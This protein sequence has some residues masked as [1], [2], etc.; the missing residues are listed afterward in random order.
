MMTVQQSSPRPAHKHP[1][2]IQPHTSKH[3]L[4]SSGSSPLLSAAT[5]ATT[6]S[7]YS[8]SINDLK[9]FQSES[10]SHTHNPSAASNDDGAG[11][12][13]FPASGS[14]ADPAAAAAAA[15]VPIETQ[16][17]QF[18]EFV[19]TIVYLFLDRLPRDLPFSQRLSAPFTT[20]PKYSEF[21]DSFY[22]S[23]QLIHRALKATS[24][25][26]PL[27][28]VVAALK[29]IARIVELSEY[30][31]SPGSEGYLF[32]IALMT[33]QKCLADNVYANSTWA[34]ITK[35]PV[36]TLNTLEFEFLSCVDY[37]LHLHNTEY[38]EFYKYIHSV[39]RLW[40]KPV[41]ALPPSEETPITRGT[42]ITR[43][44]T[45]TESVKPQRSKSMGSR[46][47]LNLQTATIVNAQVFK[48]TMTP[49]TPVEAKPKSAREGEGEGDA[50]P[51]QYPPSQAAYNP[52]GKSKSFSSSQP[53][54]APPPITPT[55][56][57]PPAVAKTR[58]NAAS[59]SD[60]PVEPQRKGSL[61]PSLLS[62]CNTGSDGQSAVNSY[63]GSYGGQPIP[64]SPLHY[65]SNGSG[66]WNRKMS[67]SPAPGTSPPHDRSSQYQRLSGA[68]LDSGLQIH[69]SNLKRSTRPHSASPEQDGRGS[70]TPTPPSGPRS[71][72]PTNKRTFGLFSGSTFTLTGMFGM[73]PPMPISAAPSVVSD[74]KRDG[75]RPVYDRS[76][77][78]LSPIPPM[79]PPKSPP[80]KYISPT[81]TK[82][83]NALMEVSIGR[84]GSGSGSAVGSSSYSA[85][86]NG[87]SGSGSG[88]GSGN[89][90]SYNFHPPSPLLKG[91]IQ[92]RK[93]LL[94]SLS[95]ANPS[96]QTVG[97]GSG[98]ELGRSDSVSKSSK[99]K[100]TIDRSQEIAM[101]LGQASL[102]GK[103]GRI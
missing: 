46:P 97:R 86:S 88:S 7:L 90:Q 58:S 89:D 1:A 62:Y 31:S 22:C 79:S 74:S 80:P 32:C 81:L 52:R 43:R 24:K 12:A 75:S 30:A 98:S 78:V 84:G 9:K 42:A 38:E 64:S 6:A 36:E 77:V 41:T 102:H 56:S 60:R 26:I 48:T 34:K 65:H 76:S 93:K 87:S 39:A 33:S 29:L 101:L 23:L 91:S 99:S 71:A 49:T 72:T 50:A 92:R 94:Q 44:P 73:L 19:C 68:V 85:V 82:V 5:T 14:S 17:L 40:A 63:V 10:T 15:T 55:Y 57:N 95:D 96:A 66:V 35:L 37:K 27:P 16:E 67:S 59:I 4:T 53:Q 54:D 51:F 11:L 3:S 8:T 83:T 103:L 69:G 100:K 25:A 61:D 70:A 18:S 13:G 21:R 28:M 20:D 45:I 2:P 47:P